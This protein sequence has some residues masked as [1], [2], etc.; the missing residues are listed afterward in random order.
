MHR[1]E[2]FF[3]LRDKHI[4]SG[5]GKEGHGI[6]LGLI[7]KF[8]ERKIPAFYHTPHHEGPFGKYNGP[9]IIAHSLKGQG[10]TPH[11]IPV[12]YVFDGIR[13]VVVGEQAKMVYVLGLEVRKKAAAAL[14][15][16][17]FKYVDSVEARNSGN[18]VAFIFETAFCIAGSDFGQL[19]GKN[20]D[21]KIAV[22]AGG[23]QEAGFYALGFL[24]NQVKHGVD[25]TGGGVNLTIVGYSLFGLYLLLFCHP[26]CLYGLLFY[27]IS[28][29]Y[30]ILSEKM[31]II[32]P[33]R[34][35]LSLFFNFPA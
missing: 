17:I 26:I 13:K 31:G 28:G 18:S 11:D 16:V 19:A 23:F 24:F 1:R 25:F 7:E 22:A 20:F 8:K 15:D 9:G 35:R 6:V 29:F 21:E 33:G 3:G 12:Q 34:T 2:L 32:P 14:E 30:A 4:F 10:I 27:H 5:V